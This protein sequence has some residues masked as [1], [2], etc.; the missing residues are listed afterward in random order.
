MEPA[1]DAAGST[2][3]ALR[4]EYVE[5]SDYDRDHGLLSS[6]NVTISAYQNR[7]PA[8]YEARWRVLKTAFTAIES[9]W[10]A[11]G[12]ME[13]MRVFY[14]NFVQPHKK[15]THTGKAALVMLVLK[16]T[17]TDLAGYISRALPK[18]TSRSSPPAG[19][20]GPPKPCPVCLTDLKR[21]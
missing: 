2:R 4:A 13:G 8:A 6:L 10:E 1:G 5:A 21:D 18:G 12:Q 7:P 20:Y 16:K 11:S 15:K 9:M 14:S 3:E 17:N 19:R